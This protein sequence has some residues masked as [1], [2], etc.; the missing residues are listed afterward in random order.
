MAD[1]P[2]RSAAVVV[3]GEAGIGKT[4]P[5]RSI[6]AEHSGIAVCKKYERMLLMDVQQITAAFDDIFD[7]RVDRV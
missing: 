2:E 3:L 6:L 5:V 7:L 1:L 4:V